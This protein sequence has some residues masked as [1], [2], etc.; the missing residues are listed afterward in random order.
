MSS[1]LEEMGVEE[2]PEADPSKSIM[3]KIGGLN[4]PVVVSGGG[5]VNCRWPGIEREG[6]RPA[7]SARRSD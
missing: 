1:T 6:A 2:E 4:D 3:L 7:A 5:V